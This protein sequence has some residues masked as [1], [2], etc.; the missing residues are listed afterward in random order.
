MT[1][2]LDM[3]VATAWTWFCVRNSDVPDTERSTDEVSRMFAAWAETRRLRLTAYC[4]CKEF[5]A[6][7]NISSRLDVSQ[8][9]S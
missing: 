3:P 8:T 1:F 2:V 5:R 6:L 7:N 9:R 4:L